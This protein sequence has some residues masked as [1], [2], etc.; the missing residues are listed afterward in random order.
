VVGDDD[1]SIYGWRGADIANILDFER[2]YPDCRIIKL[3]RNYRST[4]VILDT[5][6]DVVS[7]IIGRKPKRLF[8]EMTGGDKVSLLLC[9]DETDEAEAVAEKINSGM[10]FDKSASDFAV[11]YRTNAQSRAIEDSLR[12]KGLPY[13]IVGGTKFYERAE[14]KD[15][16]AYLRLLVN[17]DDNLAL[18]RI[19]NVPRR[20]VGKTSVARLERLASEKG[21][22]L[23]SIVQSSIDDAGIKGKAKA[24]LEKFVSIM[25]ELSSKVDKS[26]PQDIAARLIENIKYL[27]A[28]LAEG[29]PEAEVRADNVRELVAGIQEYADREESPTLAGFLEEVALITDIDT[30]DDSAGSVT[31][32]TMHS[33]K[34]LEFDTVFMVGMEDGLFPL[35]RGLDHPE[36]LDEERRLCYVGM[37]RA[38]NKLCLSMAGFRRRWGD[39]TG[40]PSMFLKDIPEELVEVERFNYWSDLYKGDAARPKDRQPRKVRAQRPLQ[41]DDYDTDDTLP[42][43]TSVLHDKFGRGVVVE[44]EGSGDSLVVAIRFE[45]AGNKKLMVKYASLEIIAR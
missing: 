37:T 17:P 13:T 44:R 12:Y 20:G 16:L 26:S 45:T 31:L 39:Y 1:Q 42:V 3:E 2:D 38:R 43:G 41:F 34:G 19:I 27:E 6:G 4:Q 28:L 23:M 35:Q 30:W 10:A 36:D 14:V 15:I 24:E 40:G 29:T 9:G 11:L 5:A 18:L 25:A 7:K 22:S 8:T 32:M 33:A 21:Q